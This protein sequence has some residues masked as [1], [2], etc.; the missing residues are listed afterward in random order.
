MQLQDSV[1]GEGL[2]D[3][4]QSP[5]TVLGPGH[6]L[7]SPPAGRTD[8]SL[9]CHLW[10]NPDALSSPDLAF[11]SLTPECSDLATANLC[12][13]EQLCQGL[14]QKDPQVLRFLL[15]SHR[16]SLSSLDSGRVR[17]GGL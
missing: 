17:A 15:T 13:G 16:L 12:D 6:L 14:A 11:S 2:P 7:G 5:T 3:S 4:S 10:R 1:G 9:S 8:L